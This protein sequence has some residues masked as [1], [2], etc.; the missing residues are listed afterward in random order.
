M[1]DTSS[2]S[3][4][5]PPKKAPMKRKPYHARIL[6]HTYATTCTACKKFLPYTAEQPNGVPA[7]SCKECA[8]TTCASCHPDTN[9][10]VR[11]EHEDYFCKL[12]RF[13]NAVPLVYDLMAMPKDLPADPLADSATMTEAEIDAGY[14]KRLAFDPMMETCVLEY[15]VQHVMRFTPNATQAFLDTIRSQ[16]F[17]YEKATTRLQA[18]NPDADSHADAGENNEALLVDT[19]ISPMSE[20]V[21]VRRLIQPDLLG[22]AYFDKLFAAI[23]LKLQPHFDNISQLANHW[24]GLQDALQFQ[25]LVLCNVNTQQTALFSP[26]E[27][28]DIVLPY[29]LLKTSIDLDSNQHEALNYSSARVAGALF[30]DRIKEELGH[31]KKKGVPMNTLWHLTLMHTRKSELEQIFSY[32]PYAAPALTGK[33]TAE[34]LRELEKKRDALPLRRGATTELLVRLMGDPEDPLLVVFQKHTTLYSLRAWLEG[35]IY[36]NNDARHAKDDVG[37]A[38]KDFDVFKLTDEWLSSQRYHWTDPEA[39]FSGAAK[40][41]LRGTNNLFMFARAV[42]TLCKTGAKSKEL[43]IA[44]HDVTGVRWPGDKEHTL[45]P[46]ILTFARADLV[47]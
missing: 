32:G 9:T 33:E 45:Y 18:P 38:P 31:Y 5:P 13:S 40:H 20:A 39:P 6:E 10:A 43:R 8:F 30:E 24:I 17:F 42:D 28:K 41:P 35:N 21:A 2:S 46:F 11:A 3:T 15:F 19:E 47:A 1:A 44:Y 7:W 4:S 26:K 14:Q 37:G 16:H 36:S 12:A 22:G 34:E 25:S 29:H 27:L 23:V